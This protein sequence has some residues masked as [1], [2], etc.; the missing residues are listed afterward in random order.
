[1]LGYLFFY[2]CL[3]SLI[4][5]TL[6]FFLYKKISFY[7]FKKN[8]NENFND[9][10]DDDLIQCK[11]Y[12]LISKSPHFKYTNIIG[13]NKNSKFIGINKGSYYFIVLSKKNLKINEFPSDVNIMYKHEYDKILFEYILKN[14][15]RSNAT[16]LNYEQNTKTYLNDHCNFYPH[17]DNIYID[18]K[19]SSNDF[20]IVSINTFFEEQ[21]YNN[22]FKSTFLKS[23]NLFLIEFTDS[24][25]L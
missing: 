18:F 23:N 17:S 15:Y 9:N 5:I 3:F 22:I 4:I 7:Q 2:I 25:E 14:I 21:I 1:M 16:N 24:I 12:N 13:F 10:N 11:Y 6:S 19:L 8:L 20:L